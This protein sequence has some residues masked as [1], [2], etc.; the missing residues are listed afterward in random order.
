MNCSYSMY[1]SL[2]L[3]ILTILSERVSTNDTESTR[4]TDNTTLEDPSTNKSTEEDD[5]HANVSNFAMAEE[6]T[7]TNQSINIDRN[8]KVDQLGKIL[9]EKVAMLQKFDDKKVGADV[10]LK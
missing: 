7:S 10:R 5:R 8:G 1:I 6:T 2:I 4:S 3:L 9:K